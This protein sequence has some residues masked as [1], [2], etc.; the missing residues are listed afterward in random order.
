MALFQ[1]PLGWAQRFLYNVEQGPLP[2]PQLAL[3]VDYD[4][5][6]EYKTIQVALVS[7]VGTTSV[8]I[9]D[10]GQE[11]H[12]LVTHLVSTVSTSFLAAD[13]IRLHLIPPNPA[14]VPA[15]PLTIQNGYATSFVSMIRSLQNG[16]TGTSAFSNVGIPPV[17]V[18]PGWIL[19]G[20]I[21]SAAAGL[22]QTFSG[23]VWERLKSL[24]VSTP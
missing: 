15:I 17:Y 22:S 24:P 7:V 8:T 23:V 16:L 5:P 10:P 3:A 18:P 21:T 13:T 4:W 20:L 6:L 14:A 9:Y 12:G 11:K 19:Q 1:K 2:F